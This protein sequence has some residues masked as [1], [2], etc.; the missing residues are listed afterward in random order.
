MYRIQFLFR[1]GIVGWLFRS[2]RVISD[3]VFFYYFEKNLYDFVVLVV[4]SNI[5]RKY[6]FV[7]FFEG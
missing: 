1:V 7:F 2:I 6:I 4:V 3:S 5:Y